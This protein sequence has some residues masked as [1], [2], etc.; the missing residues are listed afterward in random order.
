ML[1]ICCEVNSLPT[2]KILDWS[3]TKVFADDKLNV[4]KMAKFSF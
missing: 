4:D 2:D 1:S 3:K